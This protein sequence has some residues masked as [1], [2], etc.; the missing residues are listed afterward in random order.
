M[1]LRFERAT[2]LARCFGTGVLPISLALSLAFSLSA[3]GL[4]ISAQAQPPVPSLANT[5]VI[6]EKTEPPAAKSQPAPA[7]S[8][9][10]SAKKAPPAQSPLES[11][12]SESEAPAKRKPLANKFSRDQDFNE[13]A[14]E[15]D[16][17]S[18]RFEGEVFVRQTGNTLQHL[19]R[20]C[21]RD[22]KYAKA[23]LVMQKAIKIS[24]ND[25]ENY[26][27]YAEA[28]Q[29][30]LERQEDKD[31]ELFNKCVGVW[32]QVLRSEVGEEKGL[33]F[34]GISI[35]NGLYG[36]EDTVF[37]AKRQLRKLTGY[38]PKPWETDNKYLVRVLRSAKTSVTA[39][40]K[41]KTESS[42]DTP[43]GV[44][45]PSASK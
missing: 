40:I 7:K 37:K 28:M 8:Q 9:P 21:I 19:G 25:V 1:Y 44:G 22:G 26:V 20:D 17:N 41:L 32:L 5:P 39:E 27:L 6:P 10:A 24:P 23:M 45:V 33:S 14:G 18:G 4:Y 3:Q 34:K 42:T 38:V 12:E 36:D 29:G 15:G 35:D 11:E 13:D 30:V 16:P 43:A 2:A 31:P